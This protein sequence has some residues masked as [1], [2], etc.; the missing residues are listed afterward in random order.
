[1]LKRIISRLDI[2]N[3]T[4]VK[5][6]NLEGLRSLGDPIYFAKKY[7]E[8]G[9]D[10]I[11]YQDVVASL[12]GRNSLKEII[13]ECVKNIF[14][15]VCVGG[16]LRN[17]NDIDDVLKLGADKISLN[18]AAVR[19]PDL[20]KEAAN[21]YGSSTISIS[22]EAIKYD[23]KYEVL[24]ESGREQTGIELFSWIEKIQ[25]YG[26]GE[27]ILTS[28][29]NEGRKK[30]FDLDLY[31][32]VKNIT[33]VPV[34]AHGGAGNADDI[35]NLFQESD[36]EGVLLSSILHYSYLDISAKF[37]NEGK[38]NYLNNLKLEFKNNTSIHE[39]K[40]FLIKK[41]VKIRNI[42]E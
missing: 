16:G 6:I 8:E 19:K 9:I 5:G 37:K 21:V 41:G 22:I 31:K 14:V 34:I 28:I 17:L 29:N 1:M 26:A 18:S 4:L 13:S 12:Y 40:K 42:D 15:A 30:G 10:E 20:I 32:K 25:K 39:I 2:K 38:N 7:Y 36:V 24:I 23:D 11:H 35:Y 3:Q 33:S 27:I